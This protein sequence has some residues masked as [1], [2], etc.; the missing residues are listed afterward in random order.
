MRIL[1][2]DLPM[3]S[4][5]MYVCGRPV[6]RHGTAAS[7]PKVDRCSMV[8]HGILMLGLGMWLRGNFFAFVAS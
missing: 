6:P 4:L 8:W 5:Y 7:F 3:I 1:G 2:G